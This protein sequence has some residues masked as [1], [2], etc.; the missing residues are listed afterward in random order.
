MRPR[1]RGPR[2]AVVVCESVDKGA[3]EVKSGDRAERGGAHASGDTHTRL[4]LAA[5]SFG[6]A[7]A[8]SGEGKSTGGPLDNCSG[9]SGSGSGSDAKKLCRRCFAT[10]KGG[11]F[12]DHY[13]LGTRDT[14]ILGRGNWTV[15]RC[16]HRLTGTV[17]AVKCLDR[18]LMTDA[19]KK[20][21]VDEIALMEMTSDKPSIHRYTA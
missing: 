9:G 5:P 12:H 20:A 17:C 2:E 14:D 18:R 21:L 13:R 19:E 11:G 10:T 7:A 6:T 8:N 15:R 4:R 1:G 16:V 3:R